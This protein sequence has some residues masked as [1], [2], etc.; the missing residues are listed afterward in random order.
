MTDADLTACV[1]PPRR[2]S[3][4]DFDV[5]FFGTAMSRASLANGGHQQEPAVD[6]PN[7]KV[8]I[9]LIEDSQLDIAVV[10]QETVSYFRRRKDGRNRKV[11]STIISRHLIES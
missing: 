2:L 1:F 3:R 11:N 8:G 10:G 9:G 6:H 5:F 7:E 4:R